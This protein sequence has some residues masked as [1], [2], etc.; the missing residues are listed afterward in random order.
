MTELGD[1]IILTTSRPLSLNE[2]LR[3]QYKKRHSRKI[4]Q[5]NVQDLSEK[6]QVTKQYEECCLSRAGAAVLRLLPASPRCLAHK[7]L[8]RE[9]QK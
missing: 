2:M 5:K 8:Q 9:A 6:K 7:G 4:F 1:L 3:G